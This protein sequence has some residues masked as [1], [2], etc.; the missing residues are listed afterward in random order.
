MD[1]QE[2]ITNRRSVRK[3]TEHYVTNA[4]LKQVLEAAR[5]APSWANTQS[6][7]FIVVRDRE[8]IT[9]ITETYSESNPARKCS[10]G[11]SALIIGCA[12]KNFSGYKKGEQTTIF[13]D[14][15]MFDLGLAVQNL[16]LKAHEVGLGTVI[17][18]LMDHEK[19]KKIL[20][21]PEEYEVVVSIPIGK[22]EEPVK[23]GTSRKEL[24]RFIH[25]DT[26]NSIYAAIDS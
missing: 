12:K 8:I 26:F 14:W 10:L 13:A 1:L 2:A 16:C 21:V 24:K 18:G 9:E 23:K 19:C 11:A 15:F 22:P 25:L 17:V 4:E 20:Q 3:F 6:W 5:Y 7:E